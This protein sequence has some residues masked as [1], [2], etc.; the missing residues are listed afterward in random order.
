[1]HKK[2][3][4]VWTWNLKNVDSSIFLH[5]NSKKSVAHLIHSKD[6][7]KAY[8]PYFAAMERGN[9]QHGAASKCDLIRIRNKL[10]MLCPERDLGF[11]SL[12]LRRPGP[13][14][15]CFRGL[16]AICCSHYK[17]AFQPAGKA[18][19]GPKRHMCRIHI[20]AK[21]L[22][23]DALSRGFLLFC[24]QGCIFVGI[25]RRTTHFRRERT[26]SQ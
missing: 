24:L 21:P 7:K 10:E 13:E 14:S 26:L 18:S 12:T 9:R 6:V 20:A 22:E 17:L 25:A 19:A 15:G 11:E 5:D 23:S 3:F 2:L 16:F 8:C 1:M 4:D